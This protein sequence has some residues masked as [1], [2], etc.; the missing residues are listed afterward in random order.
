MCEIKDFKL[1]PCPFCGN[2]LV[3]NKDHH[4]Y[5]WEHNDLNCPCSANQILDKRDMNTWNKRHFNLTCSKCKEN[6]PLTMVTPFVCAKCN[7]E[8]K[9]LLTEQQ[10][11]K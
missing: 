2:K 1:K 11:N 6:S 9:R 10:R 4:G 7:E 5:Y 8:E 3:L